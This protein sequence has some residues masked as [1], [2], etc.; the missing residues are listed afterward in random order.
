MVACKLNRTTG[1]YEQIEIKNLLFHIYPCPDCPDSVLIP[2]T[3]KSCRVIKKCDLLVLC[4]SKK[5]LLAYFNRQ[6]ETRPGYDNLINEIT[7][8]EAFTDHNEDKPICSIIDKI[9]NQKGKTI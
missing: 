3:N 9:N 5:V 4:E 2:I 6:S 8:I 1:M 7:V